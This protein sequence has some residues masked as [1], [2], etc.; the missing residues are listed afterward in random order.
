MK[1][2]IAQRTELARKRLTPISAT[3]E[4][5]SLPGDGTKSASGHWRASGNK[6]CDLRWLLTP[7]L[8]PHWRSGT[9]SSK[10]RRGGRGEPARLRTT[11]P[12]VCIDGPVPGSATVLFEA[13]WGTN[14]DAR[15]IATARTAMPRLL[16]AVRRY[17][18][19]RTMLPRRPGPRLLKSDRMRHRQQCAKRIREAI[20]A[21]L[22]GTGK[23][24]SEDE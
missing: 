19:W 15:F 3:R 10:Q 11:R 9:R 24:G 17:W 21:E 4:S 13:D 16:A 6:G 2:T 22:A 20:T 23:E 18:N 12:V 8:L 1:L 7:L 14:A 5:L